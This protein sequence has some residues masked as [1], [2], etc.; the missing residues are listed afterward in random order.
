MRSLV[1]RLLAV[2]AADVVRV[3]VHILREGPFDDAAGTHHE[4]LEV[5]RQYD[6]LLL[7]LGQLVDW[8]KDGEEEYL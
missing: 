1:V 4:P 8:R 7:L 6:H 2:A 5:L 3:Y